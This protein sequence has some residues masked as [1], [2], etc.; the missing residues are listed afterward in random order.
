MDS[1]LWTKVDH[2]LERVSTAQDAV[3]EET[4]QACEQAG[5]PAIAVSPSQGK[6]L[7]LLAKSI[8]AQMILE[9]G[10]L[11]G[12]STI[13]LARALPAG[14][15]AI[16]LEL[17][18]THAEVARQNIARA[19]LDEFVDIRVGPALETLPTLLSEFGATFDFVFIDADK[20]E[21][22]EYLDW[23]VQLTKSGGLILADNVVREGEVANPVNTDPQVVGARTF[24]DRVAQDPRLE[25]TVMQTVGSKGHDGF[26]LIRVQHQ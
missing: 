8:R 26:A 21:L 18:P 5:L 17:E 14:G 19:R 13:W 11:G 23:S 25:S 12:Y 7:Y 24:L 9:I 1:E 3:L 6:L 10:T 20:T 22:A 4:L 16:S 15:R 2:Y